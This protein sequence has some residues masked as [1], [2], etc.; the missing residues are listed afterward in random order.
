MAYLNTVQR[1]RRGFKDMNS[2]LFQCP[3]TLRELDTGIE[4]NVSKL[5]IVQPVTVRL[6][7]PF[8]GNPHKWKLADGRIGEPAVADSGAN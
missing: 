2:L 4:V 8:C 1:A 6:L 7:C 5:Q 3:K